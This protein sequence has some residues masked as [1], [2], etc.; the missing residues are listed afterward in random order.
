MR[1]RIH[2]E[3]GFTLIELMVVV[4]IIGI[5]VAI[6]VPVYFSAQTSAKTNTC[7]AN[8][9]TLDGA[10]QTYAAEYGVYPVADNYEALGPIMV[11]TQLKA[12][13]SCPDEGTYT[14]SDGGGTAAASVTCDKPDHSY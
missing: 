11:P 6:A 2:R 14:Y 8:L 10:L 12:L 3:E 1:K 4:L 5:L 9:R 7:K 13:P